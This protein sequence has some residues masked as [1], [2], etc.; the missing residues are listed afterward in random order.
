MI[1][2]GNSAHGKSREITD[3]PFTDLYLRL[4]DENCVIARYR[5]DPMRTDTVSGHYDVSSAYSD[6][7]LVVRD[8][9]FETNEWEGSITFKGLRLRYAKF[10]AAEE[11]LWASIRAVPLDLPDLDDLKINPE[12]VKKIRGWGDKKGCI[13]IGGKTGEG[14]TTTGVGLLKDYLI[15][16]GGLLFTCEDPIEYQLQGALSDNSFCLQYEV[17]DDADWTPAIKRAMRA[18]PD[19]IL[20]GEIRTPEAAEQFLQASMSGHLVVTTVHAGTA[21]DAV[22][23][24]VQMAERKIG[25]SARAILSETLV[26]A[27]SQKLTKNGPS[28]DCIDKGF[29]KHSTVTTVIKKGDLSQLSSSVSKYSPRPDRRA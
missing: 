2:R 1:I 29:D 3:L 17:K 18:R 20:V 15:R 25:A 27:L 13:I 24:V 14:K 21:E 5:P 10:N 16:R 26:G 11:E 19:Y 9:I 4:D 7:I 8:R 6:D 28:V 22:S 23:A 12:L